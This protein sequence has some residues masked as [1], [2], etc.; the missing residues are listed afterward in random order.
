MAR[1]GLA[2]PGARGWVAVPDTWRVGCAATER[3]GVTGREVAGEEDSGNCV[4]VVVPPDV[5]VD[6]AVC[7]ESAF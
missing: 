4:T 7:D 5:E 1:D 6:V 3:L 2:R